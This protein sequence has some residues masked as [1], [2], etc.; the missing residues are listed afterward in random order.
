[1][2]PFFVGPDGKVVE[3]TTERPAPAL[4]WYPPERWRT[5][6][7]VVVQTLP[8]YL[9]ERWAVAVGVLNGPAWADAAARWPARCEKCT[10][11]TLLADNTWA[12]VGIYR[13]VGR[14]LETIPPDERGGPSHPLRAEFAGSIALLGY[15][16]NPLPARAGHTVD[17]LLYWQAQTT[18]GRN[19]NVFLH[20]RDAANTNVAQADGIPSW[21]G[22][23]PTTSWPPGKTVLD[24]HALL[25]PKNLPPGRYRL[26]AGLYD[27]QTQMRLPLASGGDEVELATLEILGS[28]S[29]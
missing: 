11:A 12:R 14:A 1:P 23:Q 18:P 16:V 26:V 15:D 9:P 21:Y 27:W 19:Y 6:E 2:W 10:E 5:G 8:W 3:D 28:A 24:A 20:L 22:P 7:T 25:L 29:R 17:V 4:L 13:R